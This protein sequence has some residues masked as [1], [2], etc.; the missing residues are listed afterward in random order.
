[1][2][3]A[4]NGVSLDTED[5]YDITPIK[6]FNYISADPIDINRS[7]GY[8][9]FRICLLDRAPIKIT[10]TDS[11]SSKYTSNKSALELITEFRQTIIDEWNKNPSKIPTFNL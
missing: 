2:R 11:P 10:K 8:L 1:M 3:I 6:R 7:D 5:I 9:V 4:I